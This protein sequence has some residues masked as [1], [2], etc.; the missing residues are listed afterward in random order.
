M[1]MPSDTHGGNS[2]PG[3]GDLHGEGTTTNAHLGCSPIFSQSNLLSSGA[4]PA[5]PNELCQIAD[6]TYGSSVFDV[7]AAADSDSMTD[8]VTYAAGDGQKGGLL[9]CSNLLWPMPRHY[10]AS[11]EGEASER[12]IS[13]RA[14]FKLSENA[15]GSTILQSA[16]KRFLPLVFSHGLTEDEDSDDD[17]IIE[18]VITVVNGSEAYPTLETD[19]RYELVVPTTGPATI[20]AETVYGAMHGLQTLSQL[21]KFKPAE[22]KYR[23]HSLPIWIDDSPR[24]DYRGVLIDLGRHFIPIASLERTIDAMSYAKLNVLH[25][26]LSDQESFPMQSHTFPGLWDSA[27]S[28]GERYTVREVRNLVKY[29]HKRGVMVLPEFDAPAHSQGMCAGAPENV[30]MPGNSKCSSGSNLPLRPVDE[31]FEFLHMHWSEMLSNEDQVFPMDW[32]HIG[33]DEVSPSCWSA[34]NVS[35]AW[36]SEMGYNESETY[37][38]FVNKHA[39]AVENLGRK[40]IVWNDAYNNG[41]NDIAADL[42]IEFWTGHNDGVLFRRALKQGY[43]VISATAHPLYL[44]N[45]NDYNV[46][47][48]YDYDPCNC[49]DW[50]NDENMD[51]MNQTKYCDQVLGLEAAFWT[52]DYDASNLENGLWPR[53]AAMAERAWSPYFLDTYVNATAAANHGNITATS[54]RL[55]QFRCE[56]M[57]RGVAALPTTA[58]WY[59]K[60][61]SNRPGEAGSCMNQ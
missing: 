48:V 54:S 33:G 42:T 19:V 34:D 28:D 3:A 16:I 13:S 1:A 58:N 7:E 27:F 25:L 53:A 47:Q 49:G 41:Q 9:A 44:S 10:F 18:V 59:H 4:A 39:I 12:T 24:F 60:Y 8:C 50:D 61:A 40:A 2:L 38:Y 56:L 52:S 32:A 6:M 14:T 23:V 46:E 57:R 43:K 15:K 17:V 31:T 36:M 11:S 20:H 37:T 35:S 5:W 26:H 21:V 45:S 51:C 29:A 30:C 22:D 55:G